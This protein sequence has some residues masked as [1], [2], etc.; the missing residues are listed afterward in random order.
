MSDK[1]PAT[2]PAPAL[3]ELRQEIDRLDEEMHVF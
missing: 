3:A 2:I 1:T